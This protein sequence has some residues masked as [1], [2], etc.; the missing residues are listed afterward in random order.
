MYCKQNNTAYLLMNGKS[1]NEFSNLF[2]EIAKEKAGIDKFI[3]DR[4]EEYAIEKNE[5][6]NFELEKDRFLYLLN[7][8]FT[9]RNIEVLKKT[10]DELE[11]R[12]FKILE[13]WFSI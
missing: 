7:G 5:N 3:M 8:F 2:S 11:S 1:L 9:L 6:I 10:E 13:E 4:I 12:F